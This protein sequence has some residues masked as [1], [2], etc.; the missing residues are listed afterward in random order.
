[1]Y[2]LKFSY[3]RFI[4]FINY[5]LITAILLFIIT[6]FFTISRRLGVGLRFENSNF[7]NERCELTNLINL[8]ISQ[9]Y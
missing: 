8:M 9:N 6:I 5:R 2:N 1:M 4:H 7:I 3:H